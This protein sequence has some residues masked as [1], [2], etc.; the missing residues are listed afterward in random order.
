MYQVFHQNSICCSHRTKAMLGTGVGLMILGLI[1]LI[2]GTW[3]ICLYLFCIACLCKDPIELEE[4]E[5]RQNRNN[6]QDNEPGVR[7]RSD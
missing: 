1:L 3:Q 2:I 6:E 7:V 5:Q 4:M